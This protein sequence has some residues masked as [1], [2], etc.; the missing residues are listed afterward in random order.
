MQKMFKKI[1]CIITVATM[2]FSAI[3]TIDANVND[4]SEKFVPIN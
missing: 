2:L 4:I 3:L 1:T